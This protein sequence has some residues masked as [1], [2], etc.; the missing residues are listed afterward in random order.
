MSFALNAQKTFPKIVCVGKNYLKHVKEM[1]G[2]EVPKTPVL[3]MKPWSSIAFNPN[4]L[5][6]PISQEHQVDHELELGVY[7]NKS[8]KNIKQEEALSHVGG[9]FIGIDF[10]DRGKTQDK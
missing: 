10:S 3:F 4:T 9:Y 8:G 2:Q 5:A 6:L 1:G 7:I